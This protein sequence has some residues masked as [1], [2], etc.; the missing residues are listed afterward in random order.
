MIM[1]ANG[2][3]PQFNDY[4]GYARW[5]AEWRK[6]YADL[7]QRIREDKQE[8]KNH[9]R[10]GNLGS[11]GALQKEMIFKRAMA[12][13]TM[14][15]LE[16]AKIHWGNIRKA[17]ADLAAQ[18][19]SFPLVIEDARSIDFHFNKKSL[20]WSFLPMWTLKVKGRSYYLNHINSEVGSSTRETPDNPSTKGS[21]R[22][23]RG[24]IRI[25]REGVATISAH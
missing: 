5:R 3:K 25:S 20:E 4:A 13:K 2:M 19:E 23:P 8:I 7:S 22:V 11:A 16:D 9:S 21:I 15:Q 6:L 17:Q 10:Q 24:T 12:T 18:M 1:S 14:S